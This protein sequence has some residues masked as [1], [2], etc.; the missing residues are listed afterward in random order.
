MSNTNEI[1][2]WDPVIR[3]FHWVL[4][5]AFMVA[6]LT[7][8]DFLDLHVF[9]GYVLGAA[10][11]IR[12]FWG[13]VGTKHARFSDFVTTP[14]A[15]LKYLKEILVLKAKRYLGHNPAGGLMIITM[16]MSLTLTVIT[17]VALYG[18]EEQ[19]G[20]MANWFLSNAD[21]WE[22][23]LEETHEFL[24]NFTLLLVGLHVL[25]VIAE[26]LIHKENLV[27]AMIDGIKRST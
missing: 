8:D 19:A 11:I 13:F 9:A 6:Y 3:I 17:G 16:L 18:A 26:S 24:A 21:A 22:D 2:V 23:V 12:L 14:S 20:P 10:I 27:R 7:E 5:A 15:A 1:K 4:V 25:G